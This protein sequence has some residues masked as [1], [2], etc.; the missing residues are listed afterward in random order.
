MARTPIRRS[1]P[2]RAAACGKRRGRNPQVQAAMSPP[3]FLPGQVVATP[4]AM[5]ALGENAADCSEYLGRHL[6]GDWGDLCSE[7]KEANQEALEE[8]LRLLS[9]YRLGDGTKIWIVTEA[10]RSVTTVL[11]PEEY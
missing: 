5:A 6:H 3:R 7:D 10:D 4:G 1:G 11:L 8:G 9:A 2:H